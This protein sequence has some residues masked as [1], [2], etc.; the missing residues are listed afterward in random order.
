MDTDGCK[1][2]P[3]HSS[4]SCTDVAAPA[5]DSKGFQIGDCPSGF[6]GTGIG[7]KGWTD[8]NDCLTPLVA[9]HV[10]GHTLSANGRMKNCEGDCD[11]DANCATGLR[12]YQRNARWKVKGCAGWREDSTTT[13][14]DISNWDYCFNPQWNSSIAKAPMVAVHVNAHNQKDK[15]DMCEGDCDRDNQCEAGLKCFQ[16]NDSKQV[17]G[18]GVGGEGGVRGWDYCYKVGFKVTDGPCGPKGSKCTDQGTSKYTC[19]CTTGYTSSTGNSPTCSH[20]DA[21][22]STED[23]CV[24]GAT[25]KHIGGKDLF[26]PNG[27]PRHTCACSKARQ[28]FSPVRFFPVCRY[29]LEPASGVWVLEW[30]C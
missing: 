8:I 21:C 25:C 5:T 29:L 18:C 9:V 28:P 19:G 6:Q 7:K 1:G 27:A 14:E 20:K 16:R 15:M 4:V 30:G 2:N 26:D 24:S 11:N 22:A 3:C 17:P 10:N 13:T 23:D 12:C